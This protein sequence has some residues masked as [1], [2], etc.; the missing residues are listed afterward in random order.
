M[1][2]A[3]FPTSEQD[4]Q[5]LAQLMLAEAGGEKAF[6][7]QLVGRV[8]YN[9]M[10]SQCPDFKNLRSI[11]NVILQTIGRSR[12]YHFEGVKHLGKMRNHPLYSSAME[13][14]RAIA[15]GKPIGTRARRSL[16]FFRPPHP[17]K[18]PPRVPY[19]PKSTIL[20]PPPPPYG[21]YGKH[22]FYTYTCKECP[23]F[24]K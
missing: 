1:A 12:R 6:D 17:I 15:L 3:R 2:L 18:C 5:L 24:C 19:T 16:W 13:W 23:Q 4:I 20:Q 21:R 22:C 8:V 7:M 9:R 11:Q 10:I 14:A